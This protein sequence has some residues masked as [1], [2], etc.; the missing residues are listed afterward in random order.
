MAETQSLLNIA[1]LL[2]VARVQSISGIRG[3]EPRQNHSQFQGIS[4]YCV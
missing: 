4:G 3:I 2:D 1:G